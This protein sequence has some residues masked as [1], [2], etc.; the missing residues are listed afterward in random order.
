MTRKI[1][2]LKEIYFLMNN[3]NFSYSDARKLTINQR[4]FFIQYHQKII[5]EF[6]K[7]KNKK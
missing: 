5:E 2:I 7:E 3:V 4:K 1:M 6:D